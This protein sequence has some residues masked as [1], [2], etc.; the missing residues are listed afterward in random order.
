MFPSRSGTVHAVSGSRGS[1]WLTTDFLACEANRAGFASCFKADVAR[2]MGID[3]SAVQV[4]SLSA[5]SASSPDGS[6]VVFTV[7]G[8]PHCGQSL[9]ASGLL[10]KELTRFNGSTP[11]A[12]RSFQTIQEWNPAGRSSDSSSAAAAPAGGRKAGVEDQ[13]ESNTYCGRREVYVGQFKETIPSSVEGSTKMVGAIRDGAGK[14]TLSNGDE[15]EGE[16]KDDDAHG[17][18][19]MRF[20]NGDVYEG[21]FARGKPHGEGIVVYA[22]DGSAYDGMWEDGETRP[23]AVAAAAAAPAARAP[24]G[25][26]LPPL[27][28][29]PPL[30]Q[31]RELLSVSTH[32]PFSVS[33]RSPIRK[34]DAVLC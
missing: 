10:T 21:E 1:V 32:L 34:W 17:Q 15:Y 30:S 23:P 5:G 20:N 8:V 31:S 28:S 9:A 4:S 3:D 7:E 19:T 33:S 12:A 22:G 18:G 6:T 11:V 25:C 13:E 2:A 29:L 14:I 26:Y 16:W 27:L 24:A